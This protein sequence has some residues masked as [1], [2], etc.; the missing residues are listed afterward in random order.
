MRRIV[1]PASEV[2]ALMDERDDLMIRISL[3]ADAAKPDAGRLFEL[4]KQLIRT[5]NDLGDLRR[6][7]P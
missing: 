6:A 2:E 7:M 4:Q 1:P 5:E 3:E